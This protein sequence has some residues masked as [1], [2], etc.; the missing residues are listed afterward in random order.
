MTR[1]YGN[2]RR[3]FCFSNTQVH[4]HHFER[5]SSKAFEKIRYEN[6]IIC[7]NIF[8]MLYY[9]LYC[10]MFCYTDSSSKESF[11][12]TGEVCVCVRESGAESSA[13]PKKTKPSQQSLVAVRG[14]MPKWTKINDQISNLLSVG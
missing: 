4:R 5:F 1:F 2:N 6:A 13:L 9:Y 14:K 11:V 8:E 3:A 7:E 10:S 12:P